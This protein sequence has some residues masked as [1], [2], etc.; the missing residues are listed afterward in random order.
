[1]EEAQLACLM[2]Q[3]KRN[4]AQVVSIGLRLVRALSYW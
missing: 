1:M 4:R 2:T 3:N